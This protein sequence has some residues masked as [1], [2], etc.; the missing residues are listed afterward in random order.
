MS[1]GSG[2]NVTYVA[3]L[4]GVAGAV[5]IAGAM[6]RPQ[7]TEQAPPSETDLARLARL[8][9]R[10]TLES[11]SAYLA[12]LAD[13]IA[14]LVVRVG[15]GNLSG[16]VVAPGRILTARL[17]ANMPATLGVTAGGGQERPA[18]V[19]WSP[20][21]PAAGL[22]ISGAADLRPALPAT[23]AARAGNP[24]LA[25]W[26]TAV[27]RGFAPAMLLDEAAVPCA[28][29]SIREVRTTLSLTP[30]MA[31]GG[32]FDLD[33][34]LLGVVIPC[35]DRYAAVAPD[36][37]ESMLRT[38]ASFDGRLLA[39]YGLIIAVASAAEA[40]VFQAPS[41]AV[42]REIRVDGL[43]DVSGLRP[44]DVIV[45]RDGV[46]VTRPDDLQPLTASP[47]P[48]PF[49]LTVRRAGAAVDVTIGAAE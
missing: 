20:D 24:I 13:E 3:V 27:G 45:A 2:P 46:P 40:S 23:E 10:R 35:D 18:E 16:V 26:R 31:G 32:V 41:G 9:E 12:G 39:R 44:G 22:T 8:T 11:S 43:A 36:A 19:V 33:G 25:V 15:S 6:L 14:P 49:V 34:R 38:A 42:V 5:L 29:T 47:A 30:A 37:I 1:H 48:T 7:A 17:T 21:L 28:G 4:A